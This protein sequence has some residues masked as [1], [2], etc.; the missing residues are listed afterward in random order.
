MAAIK[1]KQKNKAKAK[2]RLLG[3]VLAL[4]IVAVVIIFTA[5]ASSETRKTIQVMRVKG[6]SGLSANG[7]ITE[8]LVEPYNMY[9]KEFAQYGT[10]KSSDGTTRSSIIRWDDRDSVIGKRYAAYYMREGTVVFWDATLVD[11][12]RK[13]SYLYSIK[14]ELLN[15][16]METTDDFGDMVVPGDKLNIRCAYTKDVYDL[17]TEEKFKLSMT[18]NTE[19]DPVTQEV[20]EPLFEEVQILDMLNSNG[21]SIFD[22]YYDYISMTKEQQQEK[23]MDSEFLSSVK[24]RSILLEVTA[25][26]AEHYMKIKDLGTRYLMTLLPRTTTSAIVDSLSDIQEALRGVQASSN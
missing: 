23:L 9:Y 20:I 22:I 2:V 21:Q 13:N 4:V 24:P 17:P 10:F 15:I 19:L 7:L 12:T 1:T 18:A 26:E 8:E 14:G 16:Q 5:V 11:Q 3:V 6:G 25:E